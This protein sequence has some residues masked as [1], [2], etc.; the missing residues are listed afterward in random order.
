[1]GIE[2]INKIY[3]EKFK[4]N[5]HFC[6]IQR[7]LVPNF[8]PLLSKKAKHQIIHVSHYFNFIQIAPRTQE[9]SI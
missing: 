5:V 7:S 6:W 8:T 4:K 1:M 2:A 9:I 3:N